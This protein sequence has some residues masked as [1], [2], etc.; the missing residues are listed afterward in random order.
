MKKLFRY[1][2]LLSSNVDNLCITYNMK[3]I[4]VI[5]MSF[6]LIF[7]FTAC[8]KKDNVAD[9]S[10]NLSTYNIDINLNTNTKT[11]QVS[12][13]LKYIN[14]TDSI[15]KNVKFHLYPQFFE[16]GAT[17]YIVSN[18]KM[19]D[20]YP[21]GISYAEFDLTRV[22]VGGND[23]SIVYENDCD[24]ILCVE[25]NN[26]LM[27]KD[28][29]EINFEYNITLPNCEHRFGYG[30]NTINLANFYPIACVYENG[31][32]NTSPYNANGD[33][34][35]SDMA[36]YDV[37][38]CLDKSY[39]V[40]GTG[41]KTNEKIV[42]GIKQINYNAKLVRD[43]ALVASNKF[44]V[45][46]EKINYT[47]VE[48][49]YFNDNSPEAS[50]KAGVDS[51]RTFSEK[52]GNYPYK[53][54]SIVKTDFIHGGM[55]YPNLIMISAD[56]ENKDDYLNVIIHETAHQW[57]YSMVGNDEF[58]YPWLDEALTEYSTVLFYDYNEG[59]N[60][61]H[62]QII[63][64]NKENYTLFVSVYEDVLGSIDTS[65]RAVNEY[66][67]EPEYT[68]CTYVKGVL[69]YESL[70]KLIGEKKFCASLKTYFENNKYKNVNPQNLIDAFES[71]SK[72]ELSNFFDSWIKG[73]VVIR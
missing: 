33:P 5:L 55:E 59:Y 53:N 16:E 51:I 2:Q 39:T 47:N 4:F 68:Y 52:F 29:I 12:Q 66:S 48:Y 40:A 32:F 63:D 36:N 28:C 50:L 19:N 10:A 26:S 13:S 49:Y 6:V 69:M 18:T 17:D 62:N 45:I 23:K 21:N 71:E 11:A 54:F 1:P 73:K 9:L 14:N 41:E 34:F 57:W 22:Y 67:T 60:Y 64:A 3:K 70:Y 31:N 27:P 8:K 61:T 38:I 25:L 24:S 37:T 43:F 15:L 30:E 42:D 44:E 65:M 35:Y 7:G 58:L 20:A 56:I 46:T 72:Q